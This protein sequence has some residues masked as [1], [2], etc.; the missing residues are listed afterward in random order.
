[1]K[2]KTIKTKETC[3][4]YI[5]PIDTNNMRVKIKSTERFIC[6]HFCFKLK[7]NS[8]AKTLVK[9]I[10]P[11]SEEQ[12]FTQRNQAKDSFNRFGD[13]LSEL[14]LS[15]LPLKQKLTFECV[16]KQWKQL[17]YNRQ[18]SLNLTNFR[19]QK[20][21]ID[22][23]DALFLKTCFGSLSFVDHK[24]L[25]KL[26]NKCQKIS[27]IYI[28]FR[29]LNPDLDPYHLLGS[30]AIKAIIASDIPLK[31]LTICSKITTLT[32][33]N[34]IKNLGEKFGPKLTQ[35][36]L[37]YVSDKQLKPFFNSN[38]FKNIRKLDINSIKSQSKEDLLKYSIEKQL[39]PKL[40]QLKHTLI[41]PEVHNV[42][43]GLKCWR[44]TT[45]DIV[46]DTELCPQLTGMGVNRAL[47][48]LSQLEEL[49]IFNVKIFTENTT[50]SAIDDGLTRMANSCQHLKRL[51][52]I[53]D[54]IVLKNKLFDVFSR[55]RGLEYC[56]ISIEFNE[57]LEDY[58]FIG[59]FAN[60]PSIRVF[61]LYLYNIC[62]KHLMD[63]DIYI[64]NI[65]NLHLKSKRGITDVSLQYVRKC[66]KL[67]VFELHTY[68][69][70][71]TRINIT[72][73]GISQLIEGCPK[74]RYVL[75]FSRQKVVCCDQTIEHMI[76]RARLRPKAKHCFGSNRVIDLLKGFAVKHIKSNQMFVSLPTNLRIVNLPNWKTIQE[77]EY[78]SK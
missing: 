33:D 68:D 45:L 51:D 41:G 76:G 10:D 4:E 77:F 78:S 38:S 12:L 2:K 70:N 15:Y 24:N 5:F 64:P 63:I 3:V 20:E 62:D 21:D 11:Q 66:K 27:K 75:L 25:S 9:S 53:M 28:N 50:I 73:S 49:E 60:C 36:R 23:L 8:L 71:T 39:F 7:Y 19:D 58:G 52:F 44:L 67:E 26:L 14:L 37:K 65:T 32:D 18:F 57:D 17:I 69:D 30:S 72:D 1:M 48:Q 47:K 54:S 31:Q 43:D 6:K 22:T 42:I 59:L 40:S 16:C 55:F 61:N 35:L 13:D 46:L 29:K 56:E 74:L 34:V